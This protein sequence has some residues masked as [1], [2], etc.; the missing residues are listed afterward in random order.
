VIPDNGRFFVAAY[1][2]AAVLYGGY[3]LSLWRRSRRVDE[4]LRD[5]ESRERGG[6]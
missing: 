3:A 6:R 2:V 1:I 5:Q 4:R